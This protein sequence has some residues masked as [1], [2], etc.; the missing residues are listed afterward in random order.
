MYMRKIWYYTYVE[1][2]TIAHLSAR[3]KPN[4]LVQKLVDNP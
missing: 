3:S 4:L 2:L 1:D